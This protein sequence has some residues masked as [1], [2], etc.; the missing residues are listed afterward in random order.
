MGRPE[1]GALRP[2]AL[3]LLLQLQHLAAAAADPLS[4]GQGA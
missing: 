4:G 2:L 1:R 3:L